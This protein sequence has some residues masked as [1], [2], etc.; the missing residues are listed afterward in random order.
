MLSLGSSSTALSF[1]VTLTTSAVCIKA[2]IIL[3]TSSSLVLNFG[4]RRT[5]PSSFK[6]N[7]DVTME[8]C[9]DMPL[10][11]SS[12]GLPS[13]IMALT[14]TLVS[15]TTRSI[16]SSICFSSFCYFLLDFFIGNLEF[17]FVH[18]LKDAL[19]LFLQVRKLKLFH[20]H[21]V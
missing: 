15:S 17:F 12:L 2:R 6:I 5:T 18:L 3:L 7:S 1:D 19:P 10:L 20:Y 16:K 11:K 8:N 21:S 9:L 4:L 14:K 13:E